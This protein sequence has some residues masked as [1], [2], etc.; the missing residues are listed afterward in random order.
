M[1]FLIE[2]DR[3]QGRLVNLDRFQE[4]DRLRAE[5]TRL[6]KELDLHRRGLKHEVVLLEAASKEALRLTHRRYFEDLHQITSRTS[7]TAII[8]SKERE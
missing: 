7:S 6:Q 1:I 5:N 3:L 4:A 2:Y 8:Q